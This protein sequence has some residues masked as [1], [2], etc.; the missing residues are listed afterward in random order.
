MP[1]G[2]PL[3]TATRR[4]ARVVRVTLRTVT[5]IGLGL[6]GGS[7]LRALAADPGRTLHGY[8][9][10]PATR[11]AARAQAGGWRIH[12]TLDA[13]VRDADL[14][15]LAVPPHAT[16]GVLARLAGHP[17]LVTD[18]ASVKSPVVDA[19]RRHPVRFVAGHPM[20]GTERAGFA[21][22]DPAL[23]TGRAWVLCLEADTRLADWLALAELVLGLGA[24]V[25]PTSAA[26]H[27]AAVAR[28]SHLPHLVASALAAVAAD[29]L[30]RTLAAGSFAD[31]TRVAASPPALW[32]DIC[33]TNAEAVRPALDALVAALRAARSTVDTQDPR[34]AL[35]AWF[36][37]GHAAR[38]SWPPAAGP[39]RPVPATPEALLA[40][41]AA[42]GW[43]TAATTTPTGVDLTGVTPSATGG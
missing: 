5:V 1:Y 7:L 8:D 32:A 24:R 18:V 23:F 31:G 39:A 41:G 2:A 28:I 4:C 22:S 30:P 16:P 38:T 37:P 14:V 13:A 9:A 20:A 10:D 11:D 3:T 21:A 29:P 34:P 15:V 25:V 17:G 40:L 12:D 19:A 6:I 26:D 36:E 35:A 43:L 33:A 27:D 42:G